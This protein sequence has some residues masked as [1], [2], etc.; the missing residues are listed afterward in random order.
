V[1]GHFVDIRIQNP[2]KEDKKDDHE[3]WAR[4]VKQRCQRH[5]RRVFRRGETLQRG[6]LDSERV[7]PDNI[8]GGSDP[9]IRDEI[10][11]LF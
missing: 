9:R 7:R 4:E 8:D 6:N 10:R 5:P 1:V 3:S 11:K 2:Q